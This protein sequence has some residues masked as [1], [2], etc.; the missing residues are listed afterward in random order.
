MLQEAKLDIGNLDA[1]LG[2]LTR[3][4]HHVASTSTLAV[5]LSG[6]LLWV[7]AELCLQTCPGF[8]VRGQQGAHCLR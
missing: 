3:M 1:T 2:M 8:G 7:L 6:S 5:I 4:L